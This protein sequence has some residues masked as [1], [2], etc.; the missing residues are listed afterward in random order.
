MRNKSKQ[1][2]TIILSFAF[3][4]PLGAHPLIKPLNGIRILL[5]PGHGGADPGAI[6]PSNLKE[7]EVNLRVARYLRQ[8]LEADG[9]EVHMTRTTDKTL[10]LGERVGVALQLRPDLFLSI[11]HNSSLSKVLENRAEFYYAAQDYG[12]SKRLASAMSNEFKKQGFGDTSSYIP[13]GYYLLRN[14]QGPAII[15]EGA[16]ISLDETEKAL[17]TGKFLTN[18]AQ[19]LR[20][21]IKRVFPKELI[22]ANIYSDSKVQ[23]DC[24]YFNL[25]MYSD[26]PLHKVNARLTP[27]IGS[28]DLG[29]EPVLKWTNTHKI[30]NKSPL[31]S[32]VFELSLMFFGQDNSVSHKH[33][34]ELE[35]KLPVND[36]VINPVAS[37][38]PVG[39]KGR[40]P[41]MVTL[42]DYLQRP[43]TRQAAVELQVQTPIVNHINMLVR[44]IGKLSSL[45]LPRFSNDEKL[46][47]GKTDA[48]G[49]AMLYIELTGEERDFVAV[50]AQSEGVESGV[51]YIPVLDVAKTF[52]L[53]R[54]ASAR[55][56]VENQEVR[57][58]GDKT[59]VTSPFGFFFFESE[60]K[61]LVIDI[62]PRQKFA[63]LQYIV[64][65]ISEP[66]HLPF[67]QLK[68]LASGLLDLGVGVFFSEEFAHENTAREFVEKLGFMGAKVFKLEPRTKQRRGNKLYQG[69]L[70]ANLQQDLTVLL[71]FKRE[72]VETP[73]L[74]HYHRAGAGSKL[75]KHISQ[76]IKE[77]GGQAEVRPGGDYEIN[78]SKATALV[79]AVPEGFT[80]AEVAE[81]MA[82]FFEA[83]KTI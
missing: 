67:L 41:V 27:Q 49:V 34:L 65:N 36:V 9:A 71:S 47:A 82:K 45:H 53:G 44:A 14:T 52:V 55:G 2:L 59:T 4:L 17:M 16:Y 6:G 19:A 54:L 78:N 15:S 50:K 31:H 72:K 20:T 35:V 80:E 25:L 23:L 43:N 10:S 68:S 62:E 60:E 63:P 22:R 3:L 33:S 38:I 81:F 57:Y 58:D 8:L 32:G 13:G 51:V 83:L 64:E 11:H 39:F 18:Q 1:I 40:F 61:D 77:K 76:N 21:A 7:S 42:T 79:V 26:K 30:Y 74:R 48:K 24:P 70:N 69:V 73:Q 66:V 5:D 75:A 46:L 12:L 28:F 29:F 56:D 37:Y